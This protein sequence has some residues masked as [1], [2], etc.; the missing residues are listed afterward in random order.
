MLLLALGIFVA[1]TVFVVGEQRD[2]EKQQATGMATFIADQSTQ[3]ELWDDPAALSS[4]LEQIG[5]F[6]FSFEHVVVEKDGRPIFHTFSAEVPERILGREAGSAK[7]RVDLFKTPDGRAIYNAAVPV[8]EAN[9]MVHV[10]VLRGEIDEHTTTT[11]KSIAAGSVLALFLGLGLAWM[12][13]SMTTREVALAEAAVRESEERYRGLFEQAPDSIM[14]MTLTGEGPPVI[15]DCNEATCTM[16]GYTR[17]EIV[18]NP[19]SML[20]AP[21]DRGLIP[22]RTRRIMAGE[23]LSFEAEHI[24][25]DGSR[26][27]IEVIARKVEIGGQPVLQGIDRDISERKRAEEEKRSLEAQL[28]QAQKMEAIGGL[29]GGVAHDINNVLGAILGAAS[30]IEEDLDEKHPINEHLQKILVACHRGRGFTRNFLGY[31]RKGSF[32][33]ERLCPNLLIGENAQL[34]SHTIPKKIRVDTAL[35]PVV[36]C[37]RG[38]RSLVGQAL[39]NLCLNAVDAMD[40]EGVLLIESRNVELDESRPPALQELDPGEYVEVTVNDTGHAMD[41]ETLAQAFDPFFTTKPAGRGTGLGLSMVYGTMVSHGGIA[42]I[43]S[44]PGEGTAVT[45]LFPATD[46]PLE[47]EAELFEPTGKIAAGDGLVLLVEDEQLLRHVGREILERIGYS[48]VVAEDGRQ[49]LDEYERGKGEIRLVILDLVMPEMDGSETF[50]ELKKI[51]PEVRVLIAS[52]FTNDEVVDELLASGARG[53][54]AK[55]FD[56]QTLAEAVAAALGR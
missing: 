54:V 3:L 33:K 21:K 18:G 42:T 51:D 32:V 30:L 7:S 56:K 2:D 35:D 20:D 14:L 37:M 38:D 10:G 15:F 31:A 53:F 50:Y 19:I 36:K 11:L 4:F 16:H 1:S 28:A 5:K 24:R 52:G 23:V 49:A 48:V 8:P 27:P 9:A 17:E 55:P 46:P 34:L 43:Q 44:T 22:E 6:H 13:A 39:M 12:V 25:K 29:A 41:E 40:G 47:P 45:L 26:F